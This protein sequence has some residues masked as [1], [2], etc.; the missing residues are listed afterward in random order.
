MFFIIVTKKVFLI[1]FLTEF[2]LMYHEGIISFKWM[3]QNFL[4]LQKI[5][6]VLFL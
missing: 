3:Q 1:R 2:D 4:L 5:L 6:T